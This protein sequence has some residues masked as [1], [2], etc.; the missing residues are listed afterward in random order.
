MNIIDNIKLSYNEEFV[1]DFQVPPK[2]KKV[3]F[4]LSGKINYMSINKEEDLSFKKEYEFTR[5]Y[6]Y[7]T[8]IKKMK[9]EII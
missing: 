5:D 1:F 2:L 3:E 6:K 9:Q 8:L 7:D 4:I